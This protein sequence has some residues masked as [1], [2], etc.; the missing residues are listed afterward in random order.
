MKRIIIN[1]RPKEK[2]KE[3]SSLLSSKGYEVVEV[4]LL[5]FNRALGLKE[6]IEKYSFNKNDW[7]VFFSQNAIK[8]VLSFINPSL[9]IGV[10][11]KGTFKASIKNGLEVKF[12]SKKSNEI[13]FSYEFMDFLE[14]KEFI[15]NKN[16]IY[17]F[18]GNLSSSNFKSILKTKNYNVINIKAYDTK[19][20]DIKKRE[21]LNLA[22]LLGLKNKETKSLNKIEGIIFTSPSGIK[23]FFYN[24]EKV[25]KILDINWKNILLNLKVVTIGNTTFKNAKSAGFKNVTKATEA[26]NASIASMFF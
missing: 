23:S 13:D 16:N 5:E 11:G 19:I 25:S 26:T 12:I 15:K 20:V 9:N 22:L 1:T 3:L 17:L 24:L 18:H 21:I 14:T 8:E 7:G 2:A 4:S 6:E 10:I